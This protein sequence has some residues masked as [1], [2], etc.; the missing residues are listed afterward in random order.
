MDP[1]RRRL[2]VY[3]KRP[4]AG[5]AKTRLAQELGTESAAGFYARLLFRYLG[6]LV[7]ANWRRPVEIQIAAA[8][9]SDADFFQGG[10]P[11]LSVVAQAKGDLG[12][13]MAYSFEA[14]FAEEA[15]QV[16]LTGSDIPDLG[17]ALIEK[18]F[19]ELDKAELVL[20]PAE[21]GG[22]YLIG[23]R[24][25]GLPVFEGIKWSTDQV[26]A[27]TVALARAT[28]DRVA[29]LCTLYDVDDGAAYRSWLQRGS[30]GREW[31]R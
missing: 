20:G 28:A 5:Y 7:T 23:M 18:A 14:A 16:V 3:A 10:F 1:C 9:A 17:P 31:Q 30:H 11:E 22:Y 21:D 15:E 8:A 25:P 26:L 19:A 12:A 29:Y 27:Q 6:A 13:R 2:I 4:M 24:A